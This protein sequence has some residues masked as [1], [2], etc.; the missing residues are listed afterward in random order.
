MKIKASA[1]RL[2]YTENRK[3]EIVLTTSGHIEQ[4]VAELK[5]LLA[6]EKELAVEVKQYRHKRSLDANAY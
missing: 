2:Q 5:G 3:P 6:K 4:D 1:I